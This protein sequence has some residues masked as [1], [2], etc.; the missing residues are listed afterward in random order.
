MQDDRTR[1]RASKENKIETTDSGGKMNR[2][3]DPQINCPFYLS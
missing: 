3:P 2:I 1:E